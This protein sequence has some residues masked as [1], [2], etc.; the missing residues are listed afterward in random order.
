MYLKCFDIWKFYLWFLRRI[1]VVVGNVQELIGRGVGRL[2]DGG[3][4][5]AAVGGQEGVQ[6]RAA[7]AYHLTVG[8]KIC[9]KSVRQQHSQTPVALDKGIF[10]YTLR[11]KSLDLRSVK[12]DLPLLWKLAMRILCLNFLR[13]SH[14][15]K[16]SCICFFPQRTY[17]GIRQSEI[18]HY[19]RKKIRL[20]ESNAKCSY[21]KKFTCKG[22]L[23]QVFYLS[24]AQSSP[25][26]P[27]T[28]PLTHCY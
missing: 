16:N 26:T 7:P 15:C 3:D 6:L 21:L 22:T 23:R 28:S 9:K 27:Y 25:I 5:Q 4:G 10:L 18:L 11:V 2:A 14:F 24:E 20:M 1:C 8:T 17:F 12:Y 13:M 19:N